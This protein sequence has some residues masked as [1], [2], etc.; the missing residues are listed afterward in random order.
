MAT[1]NPAPTYAEPVEV[2][3]RTG[4]ARFAP[5]WLKWFLDLAVTLE[6]GGEEAVDHEALSGLLGGLATGHWHLT[7]AERTSLLG[8]IASPDGGWVTQHMTSDFTTTSTTA[9]DVTGLSFT[10]AA[11][12]TYTVEVHLLI[13]SD[14]STTGMQPGI[15]WPSGLSSSGATIR[16]PETATTEEITQG[17][18]TAS[19]ESA[20]TEVPTVSQTF[21]ATILATFR[22][23]AS[24]SGTFKVTLAAE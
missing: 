3:S 13:Q 1:R 7:S 5:I 19:M 14:T 18:A 22:T 6:G 24:P 16:T 20:A 21:L 17:N 8:L 23:G 12:T 9:V 15:S 4:K 10:P 2:D 11:D